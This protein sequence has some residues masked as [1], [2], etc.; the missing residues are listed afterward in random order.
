MKNLIVLLL[1][2]FF[3][4]GFL[5]SQNLS[6]G[7]TIGSLYDRIDNVDGVR[8]FATTSVNSS[9]GLTL[10]WSIGVFGEYKLNENLGIKTDVTINNKTLK[11]LDYG[12]IYTDIEAN[13]IDICPSLKVDFGK[14]YQKGF[15]MFIGPRLSVLTK[16]DSGDEVIDQNFKK[17][18]IGMQLGAGYR[19]FKHIDLQA[20]LDVGINPFY[21]S[22]DTECKF[23]GGLLSAQFDIESMLNN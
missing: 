14:V 23:Y 7:I 21:D 8:G 22:N 18:N 3:T 2:T 16:F 11:Y 15:F 6:Y 9:P 12:V 1:S 13:F 5:F 19:I 17:S 20:K 10:S 4:S